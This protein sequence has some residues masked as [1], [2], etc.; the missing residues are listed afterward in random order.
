MSDDD[1]IRRGDAAKAAGSRY[2]TG[3]ECWQAVQD[4][5][6]ALPAVQPAPDVA[7][8]YQPSMNPNDQGECVIC[9]GGPHTEVKP[10]P[11]VAALVWIDRDECPGNDCLRDDGFICGPDS[12]GIAE[13][14]AEPPRKIAALPAVQPAPDVSALVE[15]LR[16]IARQKKTDE[17]E[18]AGD[19]EY[20]D[21][22]GGYDMCIDR[23]RA[24][25]AAWEERK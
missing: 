2:F 22:E 19:V 25:L 15:A 5:I 10:A 8:R 9:G 13:G 16:E 21:F 12:C 11:D 23:A 24:A 14:R 17:L 7:H 18:T 1:M 4:A 3:P 20:A 6:A